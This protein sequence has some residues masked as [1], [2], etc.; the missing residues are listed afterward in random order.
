MISKFL[1]QVIFYGFTLKSVNYE[2]FTPQGFS[3]K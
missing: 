1:R 2:Y 3:G